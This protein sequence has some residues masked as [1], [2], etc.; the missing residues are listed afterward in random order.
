LE[1]LLNR[2]IQIFSNS[3]LITEMVVK[4]YLVPKIRIKHLI[5]QVQY[6]DK[7][8]EIPVVVEFKVEE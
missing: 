4:V 1:F 2:G 5:D 6:Q 8:M 7:I 3:N